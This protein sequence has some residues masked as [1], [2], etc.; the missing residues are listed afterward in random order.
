MMLLRMLEGKKSTLIYRLLDRFVTAQS[1]PL[2]SPRT[3]EPGPDTLVITDAG[4]SLS[5][6]GGNLVK[7]GGTFK[8]L[9][10]SDFVRENG[11]AFY[12]RQKSTTTNGTG[13]FGATEGGTNLT[14]G[15]SN[16]A[17]VA[18]SAYNDGNAIASAIYKQVPDVMHDNLVIKR[19]AGAF[20]FVRG[21][22]FG[23][24]HLLYPGSSSDGASDKWI[25]KNSNATDTGAID[26]A[27]VTT[28]G[29]VF[30]TDYGFA[31]YREASPTSPVSYIAN[32]RDAAVEITWVPAAGETLEIYARQKDTNNRFILRCTQADGIIRLLSVVSGVETSIGANTKTWTVGASYKIVLLVKMYY[33][34]SLIND[35]V[36]LITRTSYDNQFSSFG[37]GVSG[38]SNAN[39][40][41]VV[42]PSLTS[43]LPAPFDFTNWRWFLSYGDSKTADGAYQA[44]LCD[45]L[46]TSTNTRWCFENISRSGYSFATLSL[47]IAG[48]LTTVA[49]IPES[50]LINVGAND[51]VA[52]PSETDLKNYVTTITNAMH[53]KWPNAQIYFVRVWRRNY[54]V[55]CNTLATWLGD[56][57][58]LHPTYLHLGPD[59]RV[60]LENGDD[61]ATYTVDGIH[62]TLPGYELEAD[63]WKT[64]LG[65]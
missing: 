39:A 2:S 47:I 37:F 27:I 31:L 64:S 5:V 3:C 30:A 42:Y 13:Q 61:G 60:F 65:L 34:T 45:K 40:N 9:S 16:G 41:F 21:G 44:Y 51:V 26:D 35:T 22:R 24:W 55:N 17:E 33:F 20:M 12:V 6:S 43:S 59:E 11:L 10:G 14:D 1:A 18:I 8:L 7:N 52:M 63:N 38:F 19:S 56:L 25:Y 15:V 57:V 28:I 32:T 46:E 29:G 58:A 50:I 53:A 54:A 23:K 48:D 4:N 36:G 62:P 49:E